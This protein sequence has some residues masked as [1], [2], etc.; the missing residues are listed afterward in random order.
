MEAAGKGVAEV[1]RSKR[2]TVRCGRKTD[3]LDAVRAARKALAT[4]HLINPR[5]R[6]EREALR[7][8]CATRQSVVL[9]CTAAINLLKALIISARASSASSSR[10]V[11]PGKALGVCRKSRLARDARH[12]RSPRCRR[13]PRRRSVLVR[14]V[15]GH[16][17]ALRS[18]APDECPCTSSTRTLLR[19]AIARTGR[20]EPR[21]SGG[22]RHFR[23]TPLRPSRLP[24]SRRGR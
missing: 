4:E 13:C 24:S 20:R 17:S 10:V 16:S 1:C 21:P 8:L 18:H 22:R 14:P 12:A 5:R 9:A 19:L 6:G 7:V 15:R 23:H 11:A 3:M 2:P